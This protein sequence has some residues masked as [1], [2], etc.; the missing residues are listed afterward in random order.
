MPS[1]A[2]HTIVAN[3]ISERI[4]INKNS[5][6][7]GN[8]VPDINTAYLVEDIS[9]KLSHMDTHFTK[10][11]DLKEIKFNTENI[12]RFKEE[13]K[14][15]MNNPIVL[16]SFTHLLTDS[17]WNKMTFEEHYLY[18][19]EKNF[20]GIKLHSGE[21]IECEK[22]QATTMKQK[23][24]REFGTKLLKENRNIIFPVFSKEIVKDVVEIKELNI[25][26]EDV[27]KVVK[28]LNEVTK[29]QQTEKDFE[30]VVFTQ[31]E[32]QKKFEETIEFCIKQIKDIDKFNI[33][34]G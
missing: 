23:E 33:I 29:N 11:E 14:N 22:R 32:L 28:Y 19:E 25:T 15:K 9:K 13:Y 24:F 20:K 2:I 27:I 16:G 3:K 21:I 10:E 17:L 1:W 18:D 8:I 6:I 31:E 5:F 12:K 30:Y 4:N 34:K 7:F 26:E